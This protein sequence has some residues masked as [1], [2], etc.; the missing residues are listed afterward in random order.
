MLRPLILYLLL[1]SA[2]AVVLE[3]GYN[4]TAEMEMGIRKSIK[5]AYI[6]CTTGDRSCY[7][8]IIGMKIESLYGKSWNVHLLEKATTLIKGR[9]YSHDRWIALINEG[10]PAYSYYI[11]KPIDCSKPLVPPVTQVPHLAPQLQ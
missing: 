8:Q 5:D 4:I 2:L 3:K 1:I 7:S 6:N 9:Q 10:D 11:F